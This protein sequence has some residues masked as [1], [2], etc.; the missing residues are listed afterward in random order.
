MLGLFVPCCTDFVSSYTD[1]DANLHV[2]FAPKVGFLEP[3]LSAA[4]VDINTKALDEV[5]ET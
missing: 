1:T 4:R 2:D 3:R 5:P